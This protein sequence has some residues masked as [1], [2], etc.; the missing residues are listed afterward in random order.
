MMVERDLRLVELT[1]GRYHA[2]H[3]STAATVEVI[4]RAKARGLP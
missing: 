4:R 1:G 2:S 3:V